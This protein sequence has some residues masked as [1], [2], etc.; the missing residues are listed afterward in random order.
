[1]GNNSATTLYGLDTIKNTD[2]IILVEGIFDKFNVDGWIEDRGIKGISCLASLGSSI[3]EEKIEV[4]KSIGVKEVILWFE[5]DNESMHKKFYNNLKNLSNWFAVN[6]SYFY[7]NDP[8][9]SSYDELDL[10]WNTQRAAC[11]YFENNFV[12]LI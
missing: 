3:G 10:S 1:M 11:G 5:Q 2:I 9:S 4:L 6:Y 8:G 7:I 12:N